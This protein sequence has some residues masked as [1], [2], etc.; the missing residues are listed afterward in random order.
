MTRT[1][2]PEYRLIESIYS[3]TADPQQWNDV[4]RTLAGTTRCD[5]LVL[6]IHPSGPDEDGESLTFSS[7][8]DVRTSR[9]REYWQ[10]D[11]W[12]LA[13]SRS[14]VPRTERLGTD[15]YVDWWPPQQALDSFAVTLTPHDNGPSVLSGWRQRTRRDYQAE[16]LASLHEVL[17][18]IRRA[19]GLTRML[20]ELRE[21]GARSLSALD[22]LPIAVLLLRGDGVVEA[23]NRAARALVAQ[24]EGLTT[25]GG[26]MEASH[27]D[28]TQKLDALIA[29]VAPA[30]GVPAGPGGWL[31]LRRPS[32]RRDLLVHVTPLPPEHSRPS[33]RATGALGA[34]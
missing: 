20:R 9:P 13:M 10:L 32:G 4:L 16:D 34:C 8:P 5:G 11:A 28:D 21:R 2:D 31:S 7:D 26:R 12:K 18:H 30:P 15:F 14:T 19:V 17:P 1:P 3:A 29:S 25:Q 6:S 27:R 23:M 33:T 22:A 24:G